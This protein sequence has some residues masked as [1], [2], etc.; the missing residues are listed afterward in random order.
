MERKYSTRLFALVLAGLLSLS[1]S[2]LF[3]A[4]DNAA[5]LSPAAPVTGRDY[6]S[7]R[8]APP[9]GGGMYIGQYEWNP[10]DI[11]TFEEAIG[12][13]VALFSVHQ[14]MVLDSET[15]WP[16][17]FDIDEAEKAWQEGKV[18]L[19]QALAT[20]LDRILDIYGQI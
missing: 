8:I 9:P 15:E 20:E 7:L 16:V 18:V 11:A 6:S 1:C 13:N 19:V 17:A 4:D 14:P 3:P 2:S 12:R 10:G 5:V